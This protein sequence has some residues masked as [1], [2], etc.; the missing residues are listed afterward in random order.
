ME[1]VRPPAPSCHYA[2]AEVVPQRSTATG[3][4]IEWPSADL[5]VH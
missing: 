5:H 4:A 2:P 3:P 1:D